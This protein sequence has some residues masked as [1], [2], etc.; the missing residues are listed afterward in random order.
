MLFLYVRG[1][2]SRAFPHSPATLRAVR[3]YNKRCRTVTSRHA[4]L[5]LMLRPRE[6]RGWTVLLVA[7]LALAAPDIQSQVTPSAPRSNAVVAI[8]QAQKAKSHSKKQAP[9]AEVPQAPPP[10]TLEEQPPTPPQVRY[11]NGQLSID[12][13]NATLSQVLRSVQTQTGAS[14]D[15]PPGAGSER[16]VASLGPG[17]PR[18]VLASLLNGSKFN[19]VILGEANNPGAVQKIILMTKSGS[20]TGASAGTTLA[21]NNIRPPNPSEAVEPPEDDYQQPEPEV[22]N[23]NQNQNQNQLV[24]GQPGMP[25]SEGITP[26]VINPA[27]RTPEQM[28]QELQRMQQQQ[29]QMQQQLNPANQQPQPPVPNQPVAIPQE[30][31]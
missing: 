24:P 11:Q 30:P 31:R 12:S 5:T 22:E 27:G 9:V 16:V 14:V 17:K 21:Q 26:D 18:D 15:M 25:G 4:L 19:Y 29:Q 1:T 8:P 10:P 7:G 23:Q 13:R 2:T 6:T 3:G 28:L 20:G